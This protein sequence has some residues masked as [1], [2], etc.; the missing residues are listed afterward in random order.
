MNHKPLLSLGV[1]LA[2]GSS[3]AAQTP[4]GKP[5]SN[6]TDL[7]KQIESI[8]S[9]SPLTNPGNNPPLPTNPPAAPGNPI[10]PGGSPAP[11]RPGGDGPT[12]LFDPS[13]GDPLK[14]GGDNKPGTDDK[15]AAPGQAGDT[16]SK[17]P[18]EIT[19]L[20]AN[21]DQK[22]SIAI[23]T[24]E[25][26]VKD[27]EFNVICDK[28]T[29]WLKK[30]EK[31]KRAPG[32]TPA[33]ATPKPAT[34]STAAKGTPG[35][36][37]PSKDGQLDHALAI[38]TS[39]RRVIITQDKLEAD[40][41]ITHSIGKA[42]KAT[43]DANTGEVVLYGS[44]DVVKNTNHVQATDP[45]TVMY[46]YRDGFMKAVGPHKTT[47]IDASRNATPSP[48]GSTPRPAGAATPRPGAT[49]SPRQ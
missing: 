38:T 39:D 33:P 18:T 37:A 45:T 26:V 34:P 31:P 15:S 2:L 7:L 27:P 17:G 11:K 3:V 41:T 46:M 28:L 42:D 14:P 5:I 36:N 19:A 43:Y 9:G 6:E 44:P 47:I 20:E 22:A 49:L 16:K 23:F 29:A 13:L 48:D 32:T 12:T 25:V 35:A 8:T 10:L 21:F 30:D 24:G 40:G 4:A 1:I